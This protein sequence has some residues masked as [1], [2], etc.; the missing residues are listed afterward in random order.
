MRFLIPEN[1]LAASAGVVV[2]NIEMRGLPEIPAIIAM[3]EKEAVLCL[4][5]ISGR[6][7]YAGFYGKDPAFLNWAK[8]LFLYYWDKGKRA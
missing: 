6:M 4:R 1:I 3:T 2:K 8:D 7:D 5:L